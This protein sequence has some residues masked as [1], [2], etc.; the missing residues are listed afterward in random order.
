MSHSAGTLPALAAGQFP[1]LA[2]EPRVVYLDSAATT[3]KPRPVIEAVTATLAAQTANP[4][5]G[6]YPWS[7]RGAQ[8]IAAV[9]AQAAGFV[10]AAG[11]DEIVFTPGATAGLNAVALSWG[12]ANLADGDEI[13]FSPHDHSSNVYPWLHLRQLLARSGRRVTLIPYTV[14]QSGQ[15][16]AADIAA[17]LSSRTRLLAVTHLHHVFGALS[18]LAELRDHLGPAVRVCLDCSQSGGHVPVDVGALG[19]DFAVLSGHKMFGVA[20]A[21]LL[22]ARRR[23]HPELTPFLPGGSSGV[24]PAG[25]GLGQLRMPEGLEGGTPDLA[26]ISAL[27][28]AMDFIDGVSLAQITAHNQAL[29]RFLVER[30]RSMP[31]VSLL[32]GVAWDTGQ[33]GH[34]IVSFRIDG[35]HSEDIGFALAAQGFYVRTGNHCLPAG[36]TYEDSVRVSVQIY[37]S[38]YDLE[39]FTTFLALIAEGTLLRAELWPCVL[40]GGRLRPHRG[41]WDPGRAGSSW[42]VRRRTCPGGISGSGAQHRLP[43]RTAGTRA[44]YPP[45]PRPAAVPHFVHAAL[46]RAPGD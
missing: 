24:Q 43:D 27:G 8:R 13:L 35:V 15:A 44:G 6:S 38:G 19:C 4:G 42:A 9:R 16:D 45:D 2:A 32:P 5:R 14:T 30:L 20:G 37:N 25:E 31:R 10:G 36:S 41:I 40:P 11:P 18:T 39:R 34:G 22:Y 3:Q 46:P 33:P 26:A 28:A 21:G 23:V 29:T 1:A 17:K 7:S 12:L